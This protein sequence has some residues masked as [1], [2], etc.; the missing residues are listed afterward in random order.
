MKRIF[1]IIAAFI[2]LSFCL[3]SRAQN[4]SVEGKG[5]FIAAQRLFEMAASVDDY[6]LIAEEF[7]S[8]TKTDPSFAKTYINLCLVYSRIGA[9]QGEPYFSKAETALE[10]YKELAPE[11]NSGYTE[12]AISL[13][14]MRKKYESSQQSDYKTEFVGTWRFENNPRY[15]Y[16]IRIR[17][18]GESLDVHF[19]SRDDEELDTY[20]VSF[21]GSALCCTVKESDSKEWHFKRHET[22]AGDRQLVCNEEVDIIHW[23]LTLNEGKMTAAQKW[24]SLY[25]L[26]GQK[27]HSREGQGTLTYVK[28]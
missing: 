1:F 10:K 12:E 20:D 6:I 28:Y 2:W 17:E 26:D 22:T 13:K 7:E 16:V 8:V 14:A 4:I 18:S 15:Y 24:E 23:N 3:P 21:D 27:I 11:D 25:Y 19:Y 9:E 5:H